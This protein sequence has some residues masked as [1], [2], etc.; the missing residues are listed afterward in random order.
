MLYIY[1][2]KGNEVRK[3]DSTHQKPTNPTWIGALIHGNLCVEK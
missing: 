2:Q 3:S 1:L